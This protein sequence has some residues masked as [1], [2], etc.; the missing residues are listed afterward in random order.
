MAVQRKNVDN[1]MFE[2]PTN[3]LHSH[4]SSMTV[5]NDIYKHSIENPSGFWGEIASKEFY[6]KVPPSRNTLFEYNFDI[7]R[8]PVSIS[9][10]KGAVTNVCYN[11]LDH[12]VLN[13][14]RGDKIAF[15]W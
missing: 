5:Y 4:C 8:G 1:L 15:Y 3:L 13:K 11:L 14:G 10:M 6:W 12:N 9:W 2:V 7:A